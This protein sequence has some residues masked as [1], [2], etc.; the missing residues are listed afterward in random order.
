[1]ATSQEKLKFELSRLKGFLRVFIGCKSGIAGIVILAMFTIAVVAAPLLTPYDP[2]TSTSLA[3]PNGA[4]SWLK[5][6]PPALGG[7]PDRSEN[8]MPIQNPSFGN[9]TSS[10]DIYNPTGHVSIDWTENF[11]GESGVVAVTFNRDQTGEAYGNN[12]VEIYQDFNYPF[13]GPPGA[14]FGDTMVLVNATSHIETTSYKVINPNRTEV[15]QGK[16]FLIKT[17]TWNKLE[18]P[19][20]LNIFVQRISDNKTWTLWPLNFPRYLKLDPTYLPDPTR[21][22]TTMAPDGTISTFNSTAW[23]TTDD[24]PINSMHPSIN[25]YFEGSPNQ[26]LFG[27]AYVPGIYRYGMRI[28]FKDTNTTIPVS[29]RVYIGNLN[30]RLWG[31]SFGLLG[32]D[33]VGRDIW[34]QLVY[35]TRTSLYV[36]LL[37]TIIG[38]V[39]GLLVGL[40]AGYLG[41]AVDELLMRF[42]DMLLVLPN[43][44]LL[45]V[46]MAVLSPSL[47]T[48]ILVLGFLGWMG[49]ARLVRSQVL[50]L[51]E[52][53]FVEAAKAIG[54]SK[55]HIMIRHI[56]PNVMSLVFV[57]LATS[58]PGNIVA[59]AALSWLGF[60]D[61]Y[62]MS[63]G[64]M[65]Y[66]IQFRSQAISN[67]WW[68]V[69]PGLAIAALAL[70]FIMLGFAL[71]N[72]LNPK[73]RMRR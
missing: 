7:Q 73:L 19:V 47:E 34:T 54:A 48:L 49:F 26:A 56:L 25:T 33:F 20:T 13:T 64:R 38:V 1:M 14:F 36:G 21:T 42:N 3:A 68:V 11:Q 30:F 41:K 29:A 5:Y 69:P 46:L 4:P 63:W 44:P 62:R 9:D 59:E 45:I 57:T 50:S 15:E 2:I 55:T 71:D 35:G 66:D 60:F 39:L 32:T 58:V 43:L 52:R 6:V 22:G 51:R 31:N 40:A 16:V 17:Q 53:P 27:N 70:A 72:T 18:V 12:T 67:W 8:H 28:T 24:M 65:L 37:S 23:L 61:P 10:W